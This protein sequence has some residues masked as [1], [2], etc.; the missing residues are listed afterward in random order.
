LDLDHAILQSVAQQMLEREE[1]SI[2]G[3]RIKV[4][5]VSR[6]LLRSVAFAMN[7]REYRAIEQNPEKSSRWAQLAREGHKV[8]QFRDET[9][10]R[11]AAVSV[12]GKI[13]E[14]S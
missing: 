14:Y 8:V 10:G 12:D 13:K 9:A 2:S 1:I 4:Q 11:Y 3:K 7:G 6:Q 5:R